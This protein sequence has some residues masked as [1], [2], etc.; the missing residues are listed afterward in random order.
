MIN[1]SN[2]S[3]GLNI[4]ANGVYSWSCCSCSSLDSSSLYSFSDFFCLLDVFR[5]ALAFVLLLEMMV[6]FPIA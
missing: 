6:V 2:L 5:V 3:F 1:Y 4:S